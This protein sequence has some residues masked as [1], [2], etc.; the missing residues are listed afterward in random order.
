MLTNHGNMKG[1]RD[2]LEILEEG[3]A[4]S[5]PGDSIRRLIHIEDE[6]MY[7]GCSE[8]EPVNDPHSGI[9]VIDLTKV[10][11]IYV[12]GSAKGI[13]YIAQA[14]EEVLGD[15]LTGGHV[16]GKHGDPMLCK[17]IGVTL[18]GH[19]LPDE[20]CIEG[21]KK[22]YALSRDITNRDLVFTIAGNG[23]SSLL[24]WPV[25]G[26][27]LED[28]RKVTRILQIE[29]GVITEELNLFRNH[30]DRMKGGRISRYFRPAKMIHIVADDLT[31]KV[32]PGLV[33][34]Y[35]ELLKENIWLHTLSEGSTFAQAVEMLKFYKVWDS[36]PASMQR[37]LLSAPP[38][39][40]TVK[41]DEFSKMDFRIFG[42]LPLK[43]TVFPAVMRKAKELGYTP[44]ML[45]EA[46]R[47]EARE[48]GRAVS[49]IALNIERLHQPLTPPVA[50]FSMGE[51][52][53]TVDK[54][55]GVGGRNQEFAIGAA[56][57]LVG[58]E[59]VVIASVDTDGTDGP[60]GY[61]AKG[62][63]Q[64]LSGAI[65]DG[66]TVEEAKA[67]GIDLRQAL[68]DHNTTAALWP[69]G[70]GVWKEQNIG[71]TD[72]TCILVMK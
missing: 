13:T 41:Y 31:A 7:V 45:C 71:L 66:Y 57:N 64:C 49:L 51:L 20:F 50:L 35:D 69:I 44:L 6:K 4:A 70:C 12:V 62:A 43:K 23:I 29:K 11:R 27:E 25:D 56:L 61:Q 37:Y 17:K 48:G 8:F 65:V 32:S 38:E 14:L 28:V 33:K 67:K 2:A 3:F 16:I 47:T 36:L 55:T 22:I 42:I 59:K 15:Y 68:R 63:P 5:N 30:V 10:D 9:E 18:A 52:I 58:S 34:T 54:A 26:I 21:C 24:T 60:G 53:V 46:F 19:P 40:E 1:R 39:D 72:L